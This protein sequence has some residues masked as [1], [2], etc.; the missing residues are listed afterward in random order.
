MTEIDNKDRGSKDNKLRS[1]IESGGDIAGGAVGSAVGFLIG[2]PG[3]AAIGG[4]SGAAASAAIRKIGTEA[5]ERVLGNREK[6]RV[7]GAIAVAAEKIHA[8][9]QRGEQLRDDGYFEKRHHGRSDAEEVAESVLL[10]AQREAEERKIPYMAFLI[11]NIAFDNSISGAMAHQII[12]TAESLTYRQLCLMKV[13]ALVDKSR[14][15]GSDY[16]GQQSFPKEQYQ[17]LYECLDLYLRALVNF[18]GGV[19]FGPT[20]VNPRG[21]SI[22]GLGVDMFNQMGLATIPQSDLEPIIAQL[23]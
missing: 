20:D 6:T 11:G 13:S 5:T 23:S 2:G 16:R 4:A 22:Q 9:T 18:G 8:R 14:L 10:K 21:M 15:R 7:G 17:V 19:A 12:R 1:L 3:G